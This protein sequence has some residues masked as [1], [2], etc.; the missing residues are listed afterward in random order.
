MA[1]MRTPSKRSEKEM[2]QE[3]IASKMTRWSGGS[4]GWSKADN[5]KAEKVKEAIRTFLSNE[6]AQRSIKPQHVVVGLLSFVLDIDGD[7]TARW[8]AEA[9]KKKSADKS[10]PKY[11][12]GQRVLV[13]RGAMEAHLVGRSEKITSVALIDGKYVYKVQGIDGRQFFEENIG[14]ATKKSKSAAAGK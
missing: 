7:A 12:V 13:P 5:A 6:G 9:Q 4:E 2:M 1:K 10:E 14:P 3:S 8:E 11:K